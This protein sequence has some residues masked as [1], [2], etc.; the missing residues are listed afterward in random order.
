MQKSDKAVFESFQDNDMDTALEYG[1]NI[2]FLKK[3]NAELK[4]IT[5]EQ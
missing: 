2:D 5:A 3:N 1:R 4:F